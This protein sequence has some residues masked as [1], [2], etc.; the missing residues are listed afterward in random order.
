MMGG[1][2]QNPNEPQSNQKDNSSLRQSRN[3]TLPPERELSQL[4]ALPKINR[5]GL[6]TIRA[7]L[8]GKGVGASANLRPG[9]REAKAVNS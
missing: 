3:L 7:P 4:A 2:S 1:T 6:R 5:C 9:G 8:A